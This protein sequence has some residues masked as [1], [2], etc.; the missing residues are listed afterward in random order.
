MVNWVS[1]C[2]A[3]LSLISWA[4]PGETFRQHA[5]SC[6]QSLQ[7]VRCSSNFEPTLPPADARKLCNL[8]A[9]PVEHACGQVC[10]GRRIGPTGRDSE[11]VWFPATGTDNPGRISVTDRH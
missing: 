9:V 3:P 4:R 11:F 10:S 1:A 7:E 6:V 2:K 8:C 5:P